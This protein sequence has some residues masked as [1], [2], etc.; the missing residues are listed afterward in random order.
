MCTHEQVQS[1]TRPL[2]PPKKSKLELHCLFNLPP[3]QA[4]LGKC[5]SNPRTSSAQQSLVRRSLLAST[6]AANSHWHFY[7][8]CM[9]IPTSGHGLLETTLLPASLPCL[10][11]TAQQTSWP[12]RSVLIW[13]VATSML[14]AALHIQPW[15]LAR[16]NFAQI[17]LGHDSLQG[18]FTKRLT[19]I[20][21]SPGMQSCRGQRN[22]STR[23]S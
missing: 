21:F 11:A 15:H 12:A 2:L 3:Y 16:T 22:Y 7:S 4:I 23:V 17:I 8:S 9:W 14:T 1:M 5:E 19:H 6:N 13:E 10:N 20:V 18:M